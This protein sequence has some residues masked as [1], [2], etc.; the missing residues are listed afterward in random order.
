MR[1]L[2]LIISIVALL[3]LVS[4]ACTQSAS[5]PPPASPTSGSEAIDSIFASQTEQ[6]EAID[7]APEEEEVATPVA[8]VPAVQPEPPAQEDPRDGGIVEPK[9]DPTVPNNY[10]LRKGEFP[11]CLARRFD[12]D[13][14]ALLS[15]NGLTLQ[16]VVSPG[17]SLTIPQN[18]AKFATGQRSLSPHPTEYTVVSGDTFYSIACK[19]GDVYPEEIALANSKGIDFTP[20]VGDKIQIP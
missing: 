16:S 3:V 20:K 8:V 10:T 11:F 13:I 2:Y 12:I 5:T 9:F 6:A 1:K 18:A 7:K 19:F 4:L 15:A 14:A 17:Q